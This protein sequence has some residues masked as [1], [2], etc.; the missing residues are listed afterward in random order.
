MESSPGDGH[1]DCRAPNATK[2]LTAASRREAL[3]IMSRPVLEAGLPAVP[4]RLKQ[5]RRT[6]TSPFSPPPSGIRSTRYTSLGPKSPRRT[7]SS[8]VP[9][10]LG[11][12]S[13][14]QPGH[15]GGPEQQQGVLRHPGGPHHLPGGS[16]F[17]ADDCYR[18]STLSSVGGRKF[19]ITQTSEPSFPEAKAIRSPS[20]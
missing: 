18:L 14:R 19:S 8:W 10:A 17:P 20:G 13:C 9:Q 15:R 6:S 12:P 3:R 16:H 4:A 1:R 7:S 2:G 5:P 11:K